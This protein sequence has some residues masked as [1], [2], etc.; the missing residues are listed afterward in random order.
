M[1]HGLGISMESR[2]PIQ[3]CSNTAV[4]DRYYCAYNV[5]SIFLRIISFMLSSKVTLSHSGVYGNSS[6][7]VCDVH[8]VDGEIVTELSTIRG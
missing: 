6:L 5:Q 3:T 8:F 7:L 1:S 2:S 4:Q